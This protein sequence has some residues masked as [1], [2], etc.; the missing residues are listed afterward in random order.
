MSPDSFILMDLWHGECRRIRPVPRRCEGR[1]AW[2]SPAHAGPG[3]SPARGSWT[4]KAVMQGE[5]KLKGALGAIVRYDKAA[6]FLTEP[7][8]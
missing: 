7:S 6:S 1:P 2:S 5:L 3:S 4:P 8:A